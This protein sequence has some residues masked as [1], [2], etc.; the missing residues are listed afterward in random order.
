MIPLERLHT[1]EDRYYEKLILKVTNV[2][3]INNKTR[4]I[5]TNINVGYTISLRDNVKAIFYF[6]WIKMELLMRLIKAD[7]DRKLSYFFNVSF[8]GTRTFE[9]KSP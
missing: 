6:H 1:F 3:D 9:T 5:L 2:I 7:V 8:N 4:M